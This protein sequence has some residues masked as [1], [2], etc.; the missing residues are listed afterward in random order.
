MKLEVKGWLGLLRLFTAVKDKPGLVLV[1]VAPTPIWVLSFV[2]V[3]DIPLEIFAENG[4]KP[5]VFSQKTYKSG[6]NCCITGVGLT[7]IVKAVVGLPGHVK[8]VP[9]FT[10]A[11]V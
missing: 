1:P 2:Q 6:L 5:V 4:T 10:F 8:F 7:V 11:M 9:P 3:Y